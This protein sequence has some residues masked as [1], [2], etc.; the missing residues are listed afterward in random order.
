ML[1]VGSWTLA[2]PG[3][4]ALADAA[5]RA[6]VG[7]AS[8]ALLAVCV[9]VGVGDT[10]PAFVPTE[11][12]AAPGPTLSLAAGYVEELLIRLVVLALAWRSLSPRLSVAASV[13]ASSAIAA[14]AFAA[15]HR[16]GEVQP[17]NVYLV[18]RLLLPGFAFSVVALVARPAF[19]I[20][21]HGAAHLVIPWLFVAPS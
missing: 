9:R 15:L 21:A 17:S 5:A 4:A 8:G 14:L 13:V 10:L 18:T 7:L 16:L 20:A 6:G 2:R 19:L 12:S 1:A 11:E 3:R